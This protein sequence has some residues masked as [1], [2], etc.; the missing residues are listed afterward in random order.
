MTRPAA[1]GRTRSSDQIAQVSSRELPHARRCNKKRGA[2]SPPL[3]RLQNALAGSGRDWTLACNLHPLVRTAFEARP[4]S[5]LQ[6][7]PCFNCS[8]LFRNCA[9]GRGGLVSRTAEDSSNGAK[10]PDTVNQE[11]LKDRLGS[12]T[13]H[14]A[15]QPERQLSG[16]RV[17]MDN[18][19]S[20]RSMLPLPSRD[21]P[22]SISSTVG[23]YHPDAAPIGRNQ[24]GTAKLKGS[25]SQPVAIPKRISHWTP[26]E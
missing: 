2:N 10:H 21:I 15:A 4:D 25:C 12:S 19:L 11:M 13:D 6:P 26:T 23:M 18:G 20:D 9:V 3:Q 7:P 24:P 5:R 14:C 8:V 16:F 1:G 17:G 22:D